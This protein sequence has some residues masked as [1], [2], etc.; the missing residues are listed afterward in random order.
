MKF[1]PAHR[2]NHLCFLNRY[3]MTRYTGLFCHN[4]LKSLWNIRAQI[5]LSSMNFF[6]LGIVIIVGQKWYRKRKNPKA[7]ILEEAFKKSKLMETR[8]S[9]IFDGRSERRENWDAIEKYGVRFF[10]EIERTGRKGHEDA[11]KMRLWTSCA[12]WKQ[13]DWWS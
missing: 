9:I 5:S 4:G 8:A 10:T 11:Y 6:S 12:L 2:S 13:I 7:G 1:I 3:L